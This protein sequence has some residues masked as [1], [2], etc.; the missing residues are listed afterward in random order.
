MWKRQGILHLLASLP[1]R[2]SPH[3]PHLEK[4]RDIFCGMLQSPL[5]L[6]SPGGK[7]ELSLTAASKL[8]SV[9]GGGRLV[10][11][12]TI[13]HVKNKKEIMLPALLSLRKEVSWT[14]PTSD[15]ASIFLFHFQVKERSDIFSYRLRR[16]F[17]HYCNNSTYE[18]R[19]ANTMCM[20][21][22]NQGTP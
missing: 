16:T 12:S 15:K 18:Q 14:L 3:S 17:L 7:K 8:S 11:D 4:K 1:P 20:N 10:W 13:M 9:G 2:D 5:S 6:S 21:T 19:F 22:E